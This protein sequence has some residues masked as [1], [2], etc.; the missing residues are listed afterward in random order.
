[1][2]TTEK[3]GEKNVLR[4]LLIPKGVYLVYPI[5]GFLIPVCILDIKRT[6]KPLG[7]KPFHRK[8]SLDAVG[9]WK[10]LIQK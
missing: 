3:L 2:Y 1:M 5:N 10:L 7:H 8:V 9:N 4:T 6:V